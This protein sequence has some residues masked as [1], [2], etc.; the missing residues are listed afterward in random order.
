M[1][2]LLVNLDK[3]FCMIRI[4]LSGVILSWI[5]ATQAQTIYTIPGAQQQPQWVLPL[6]FEDGKG[7]K[8]TIYYAYDNDATDLSDTIFNEGP[9]AIDTSRFNATMSGIFQDTLADKIHVIK[10]FPLGKIVSIHKARLPLKM[11]W[12]PT[13]FYS[14]SLPFHSEG[15]YPDSLPKAYTELSCNNFDSH[16]NNCMNGATYPPYILPADPNNYFYF[17]STP[18]IFDPPTG[19]TYDGPAP[20]IAENEIIWYG[21]TAGTLY[22][23]IELRIKSYD[24]PAW[25][26]ESIEEADQLQIIPNPFGYAAVLELQ[27]NIK[28]FPLNL[29]VYDV[30]GKRVKR[31]EILERSTRI[32]RDNLPVGIY[33]FQLGL[34]GT[35]IQT[36]KLIITN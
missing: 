3:R 28:E 30:L 19:H 12:D 5:I 27:P 20:C 2:D 14:D 6:W 16:Y 17:H 26:N 24:N 33:V 10:K 11:R 31:L 21:D 18:C 23:T 7:V 25:V 22:Y 4:I 34:N 36:G 8:D 15:S 29:I 32:Y 35:I 9:K 1:I 13:V